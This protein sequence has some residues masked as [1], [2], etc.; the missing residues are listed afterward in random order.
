M[1]DDLHTNVPYHYAKLSIVENKRL[2]T[3]FGDHNPNAARYL[4]FLQYS[5]VSFSPA[6]KE[7]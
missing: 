5:R 4:G 1:Q 7:L 2:K 3:H 6:G